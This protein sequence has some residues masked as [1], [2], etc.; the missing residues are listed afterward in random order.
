M[1][2]NSLLIVLI[3]GALA[4]CSP[5]APAPEASSS[6]AES[7]APTPTPTPAPTPVP[8]PVALTAS[9]A[10]L[11][12]G[13]GVYNT[14]CLS[15]HAAAVLGAPKLADKAAWEARI[16]KGMEVLY[17]NAQNG[18]N[19]MPPRGGN[20]SLKDEELKAA[21]DYMVSKSL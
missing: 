3:A 20:A 6:V 11:A 17:V 5:K 18:L 7:P 21:V 2:T 1:K 10:D 12:I 13:E 14:S 15:C 16:A 8:V 4:A 9:A 19:M